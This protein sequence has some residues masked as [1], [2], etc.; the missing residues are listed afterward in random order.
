MCLPKQGVKM[1]FP[2]SSLGHSGPD[3]P[4]VPLTVGLCI[5]F[6]LIYSD[7]VTQAV[8]QIT[9]LPLALLTI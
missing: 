5:L 1:R 6:S 8:S 9:I 3:V 7:N 2:L 4:Y